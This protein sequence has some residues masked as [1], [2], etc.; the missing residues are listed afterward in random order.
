MVS[1]EVLIRNIS[2]C[3]RMKSHTAALVV[4]KN[5][6]KNV[7]NA[8]KFNIVIENASVCIGLCIRRRVHVQ[9]PDQLDKQI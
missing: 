1:F 8:K 7:P 3:F 6:T 4:T 9:R 2:L 5:R